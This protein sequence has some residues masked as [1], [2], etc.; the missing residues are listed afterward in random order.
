MAYFNLI[1]GSLGIGKFLSFETPE[2]Q[3]AAKKLEKQKMRWKERKPDKERENEVGFFWKA[4]LQPNPCLHK[5][6]GIDTS[7]IQIGTV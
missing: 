3:I 6:Q 4:P 5:W 1:A 2:V 7:C